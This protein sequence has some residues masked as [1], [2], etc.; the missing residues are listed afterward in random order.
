MKHLIYFVSI[1]FF[2]TISYKPA[3]A[4]RGYYEQEYEMPFQPRFILGSSYYNSLGDIQGPDAGSLLG[5]IGFKS[6]VSFNLNESVDLS[7]LFNRF[8]LAEES[9]TDKFSSEVRSFGLHVDYTFYKLLKNN[10]LSPLIGIGIHNINFKTINYFNSN[11]EKVVYSDESSFIL[12]ANVGVSLNVSERIKL[13]LSY[14]YILNFSDI[15]KYENEASDNISMVDFTICYDFFTKTAR[16]KPIDDS[17]YSDVNFEKFDVEDTDGDMVPDND[18]HCP[19]TPQGVKV[20][21]K[22]CAID[23]DNDG[24]ADYLDKE[25]N[26]RIGAL[27]DEDGVELTEAKYESIYGYVA[28][29][30]KYANIYN[31]SEI[32]KEDYLDINDYLIAK[33]NEFNN[34]YNQSVESDKLVSELLYRVEIGRY[35]DDIPEEDEIKM[36]MLNDLESTTKGDFVI[37]MVGEYKTKDE[38]L[39]REYE[40]DSQGFLDCYILVDN[41]GKIEK[42]A[43]PMPPKPKQDDKKNQVLNDSISEKEN[44]EIDFNK[45]VKIDEPVYRVQIGAF[46][47]ALPEQVFAGIDNVISMKDKDGFIRYMTGSFTN[48]KDGVDYMFQMRARGFEDAFLVSYK[49]GKRSI[50]FFVPNNSIDLSS[51]KENKKPEEKAKIKSEIEFIVQILVTDKVLNADQIKSI[52]KLKDVQKTNVGLNMF[53]YYAGS[54]IK[55][56]DANNRLNEV[57]NLG[58]ENAFIFASKNGE[59]ITIE[60]ALSK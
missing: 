11:N 13:N 43:P 30:R 10:R 39:K 29:S 12:P 37:Y 59:R 28:A 40:L 8:K 22:G 55:I 20:D 38:A 5:N 27:I 60:E 36:L 21:E 9:D 45:A 52:G 44:K 57:K 48:K 18:D 35:S 58:F 19:E 31:E 56:Q 23:T 49:N 4:Q 32:K 3:T 2:V 53:A 34:N 51:K 33:A 42:Y 17:F 15:D 25:L 26:T 50:E 14:N 24:I 47:E 41:N 7:L 16:D 46:K 6:G 1:L 54:F